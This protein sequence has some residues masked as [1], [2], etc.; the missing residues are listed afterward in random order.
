MNEES[1]ESR[2]PRTLYFFPKGLSTKGRTTYRAAK[3]HLLAISRLPA[4]KFLTLLKKRKG[5]LSN[6]CYHVTEYVCIG[7]EF[8]K[9]SIRLGYG[10]F[11]NGLSFKGLQGL[12]YLLLANSTINGTPRIEESRIKFLRF[13]SSKIHGQALLDDITSNS[14]DFGQARFNGE[15]SMK[16]VYSTGPLNLGESVF[17]S[18]LSLEEVGAKS[19]NAG[20]T[21]LGDL[22]L[23]NVYFESFYTEDAIARKVTIQGS[24]YS[25]KENLLDTSRIHNQKGDPLQNS[26]ATRLALAIEEMKD[27]DY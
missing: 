23:G 13:G 17:K 27:R 4:E 2:N 24:K 14:I 22:T 8:S 21:N 16:M 15:G 5:N 6:C 3:R 12:T 7:N 1:K 18:G 19:I 9:F 10:E 20:S 11:K 25:P 26:L